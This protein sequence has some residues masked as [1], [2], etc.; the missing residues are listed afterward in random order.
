MGKPMSY[1]RR[2]VLLPQV[3][4][5]AI[6]F[7]YLSVVWWLNTRMNRHTLQIVTSDHLQSSR[8]SIQTQVRYHDTLP[9]HPEFPLE[10]IPRPPLESIVQGWNI[11]GD[12]SW[13]LNLAII[14]FPKT[15]TS[16]LMRYLHKSPQVH[17]FD[18]ERC[19]MGYNQHVKLMASLYN[20]VPTGHY[21]RG[22]KC[23]RD[24]ESSLA[25]VN[26]QKYFPKT[27]FMVGLRHPIDWFESFYNFRVNNYFQMPPAETLVGRC[28]KRHQGLCTFRGNFHLFLANLGKTKI[29]T[30]PQERALIPLEYQKLI[31]PIALQG[32]IFLWDISQLKSDQE[33]AAH[34]TLPGE[35]RHSN[36][37]FRKDLQQ[38]LRLDYPLPEMIRVKPGF[39]HGNNQTAAQLVAVQ[40][41]L[42][43]QD[44][45]KE[46]R[47][48]LLQQG[49]AAAQWIRDYFLEAE[50]VVVS[51]KEY[52]SEVILKRWEVDPCKNNTIH[53][54]TGL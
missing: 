30:D 24:L 45:Y 26:Y 48:I 16:T 32:R 8:S 47:Q 22:I 50:G 14:G 19:E 7:V 49:K 10:P 23:P 54:I 38:F 5:A 20:D 12:P 1:I 33:L 43:C 13:L 42:I 3:L 40:K 21:V 39:H 52:F 44:R 41:I 53:P 27:D 4:V 29:D 9:L 46:L 25:L 51:Q 34:D 6:M 11:T 36:A 15:G 28:A 37:Q 17:I 18:E 35:V 31:Q 2:C